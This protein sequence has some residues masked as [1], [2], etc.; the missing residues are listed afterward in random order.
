[1]NNLGSGELSASSPIGTPPARNRAKSQPDHF[2]INHDLDDLKFEYLSTS[3]DTIQT[4]V[5]K[6][7]L[8][9]KKRKKQKRK[10]EKKEMN[11][12]EESN[13]TIKMKEIKLKYFKN[14]FQYL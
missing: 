4:R 9:E 7:K 12:K 3:N 5:K 10:I 1:M 14:Q 13:K 8:K 6:K 2:V 11:V